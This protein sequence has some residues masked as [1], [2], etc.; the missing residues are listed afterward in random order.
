[1]GSSQYRRR[2]AI[3]F[4]LNGDALQKYYSETNPNGAYKDIERF[5]KKHGFIHRQWSGYCSE[6]TLT[7]FELLSLF[8]EMYSKMPWLNTCAER[9]DATAIGSV[10]DIKKMKSKGIRE[11][12]EKE[13]SVQKHEQREKTSVLK[14]LQENKEII[15]KNEPHSS[16]QI[17]ET[18]RSDR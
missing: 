2:R 4:D 3:N 13:N 12:V 9:M 15:S 18:E 16:K 7:N 10:Y 14:R 17:K 8:D 6:K 5:M 11:G 1:M